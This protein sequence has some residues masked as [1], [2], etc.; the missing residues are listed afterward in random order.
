[1]CWCGPSTGTAAKPVVLE[2]ITVA[3][4]TGN[5]PSGMLINQS[6]VTLTNVNVTSPTAAG[7]G[8][9]AYGLRV[10][11]SSTVTSTGSTFV[12]QAGVNGTDGNSTPPGNPPN[13]CGGNS[14]SPGGTGAG[15]NPCGHGW[16]EG[17]GR[18]RLVLQRW[19][20]GLDRHGS[21][22]KPQRGWRR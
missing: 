22:R 11:G 5:Q 14:G 17:R 20:S 8:S 15:D 18:Q 6:F 12:A 19:F 9:S 4:G 10:L 1:V 2:A 7:T 16:R 21:V 3:G 13:G